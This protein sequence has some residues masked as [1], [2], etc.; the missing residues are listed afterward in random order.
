MPSRL[1]KIHNHR[2]V[3]RWLSFRTYRLI[4]K[5]M[6]NIH[7][8]NVGLIAGRRPAHGPGQEVSALSRVESGG[9]TGRVG[10]VLFRRFSNL[11]GRV[12][13][14]RVALTRLDP[15]QVTRSLKIL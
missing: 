9:L 6:N 5:L 3:F 13:S 14:R 8:L 1:G 2:W 12:R 15:R 4:A 7:A 11:T 10:S